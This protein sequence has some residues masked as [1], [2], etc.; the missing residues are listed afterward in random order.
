MPTWYIL[1]EWCQNSTNFVIKERIIIYAPDMII[2]PSYACI[3]VQAP[4]YMFSYRNALK[5]ERERMNNCGITRLKCFFFLFS[6]SVKSTRIAIYIHI[7]TLKLI[8]YCIHGFSEWF[9]LY[10]VVVIILYRSVISKIIESF[11]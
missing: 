4:H 7:Y 8:N 1:I 10:R 6:S 9:I 2:Y 5:R 3:C 11:I